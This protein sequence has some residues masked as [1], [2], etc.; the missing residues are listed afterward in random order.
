MQSIFAYLSASQLNRILLSFRQLRQLNR[1]IGTRIFFSVYL[2]IFLRT[3]CV[4]KNERI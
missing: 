4:H 3:Y 2:F 1:R